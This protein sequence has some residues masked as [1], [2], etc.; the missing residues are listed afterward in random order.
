MKLNQTKNPK[1]KK[2]RYVIKPQYAKNISQF[3][4]KFFLPKI[5]ETSLGSSNS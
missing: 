3:L 5:M 4:S 1:N 2:N